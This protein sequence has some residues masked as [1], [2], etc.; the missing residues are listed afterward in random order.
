MLC[1]MM[2]TDRNIAGQGLAEGEDSPMSEDQKAHPE[3]AESLP[4]A[5]AR[6][7]QEAGVSREPSGHDE[8]LHSWR[9][10]YP[11]ID[12]NCC[13]FDELVEDLEAVFRQHGSQGGQSA[14]SDR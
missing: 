13:C 2:G 7:L 8:Q 9:C 14:A 3:T 11:P 4:E 12:D 5:I 1:P 10:A 6:T